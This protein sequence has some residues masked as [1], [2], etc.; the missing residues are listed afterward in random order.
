MR[1][2]KRYV[3]PLCFLLGIPAAVL[4]LPVVAILA[5]WEV[6]DVK[7][8]ATLMLCAPILIVLSFVG[9]VVA[10]LVQ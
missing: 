2:E 5:T 8:A 7:V 4:L 6:I 1:R 9:S 3:D 10:A